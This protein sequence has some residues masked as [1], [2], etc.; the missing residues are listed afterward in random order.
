MLQVSDIQAL[1]QPD[2]TC[3]AGSGNILIVDADITGNLADYNVEIRQ[4]SETGT[5]VYSMNPASS[6]IQLTTLVGDDYFV[7]ATNNTT[8]CAI[9]TGIINVP[10]STRNPQI[11][12]VSITP[13]RDCTTPP[14]NGTANAGGIE[15]L[16]NN[17]YTEADPH[18][19]IQWYLGSDTI[20]GN[21]I[22]GE[23]AAILANLDATDYSVRVINMNT[24][25]RQMANYTVPNEPILPSIFSSTTVNNTVCDDDNDGNPANNGSFEVVEAI[26]DGAVL[27]Q[28][29]MT[30]SYSLEI[31]TNAGLTAVV[32]NNDPVSPFLYEELGVGTYYAT[33]TRTDSECASNPLTFDIEDSS[34]RPVIT[35][36]MQQADS[37]C[38]AGATPNGMLF[39]TAD[40]GIQDSNADYDFQWYLGTVVEYNAATATLL[41][42]G[43]DPGNGSTPSGVNASTLSGIAADTYTVE[44]TRLSSGCI[45]VEEFIVPNVPVDLEILQATITDATTCD[46]ANG[47]IQI[48]SV[49]RDNVTD[50]DFEYFDVDP[51]V[52][53]APTPLFTGVAGAPYT[54]ASAGIYYVVGTNTILNC[55]TLPFEVTVG[56]DLIKPQITLASFGFQAN[57][58]PSNPNG[59]F[60]ITSDGV[61]P[62][63]PNYSI[64][65]YFGSTTANTL[66]DGDIGGNGTLV[67]ADSA[68][69]LGLPN[70]FYTVEVR[71]STTGCISTETF[72]MADDIPNPTDISTST[73]ANTNCV[74][75]NGQLAA[76]VITLAPGRS[77]T[78]YNFY[79]YTGDVT[80][81]NPLSPDPLNPSPSPDFT[82]SLVTGVDAG[83]YTVFV[84]DGLDT[85][86]QSNGTL[87]EVEDGTSLPEYTLEI[88]SHVTVCFDEKDGF[89]KV[90]VPDAGRVTYEWLDDSG[91]LISTRSFASMLD[92]GAYTLRVTDVSTG[93]VAQEIFN[94]DNVSVT[95]P[96]PTVI[97]NNN[98]T[99]CADPNGGAVANVDGQQNGFLFEWFAEDDLTTPYTTG[100][101]V[102]T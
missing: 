94:I 72:E 41:A 11:D 58:D 20:P 2:T 78:D 26:F 81:S 85:F 47:V 82:G 27:N 28:V 99:N 96:D 57:C 64:Q 3:T 51:T 33:I 77:Q 80:A 54:L 34:S 62:I 15:I 95:P 89:V 69:V 90:E 35:I 36:A 87:V 43:T 23:T 73:S 50:Y 92:A 12:L 21:E 17:L 59:S 60:T 42:N 1:V 31:Y 30:G 100:A 4:G 29:A 68:T 13:D 55:V 40:G 86:C 45:S 52:T 63:S 65:W 75:P 46:P 79:W 16:I 70:G 61:D 37:T 10:D 56:E 76:S 93:C 84:V 49:T 7:I 88:V 14:A 32:T 44:V 91:V 101:E 102:F 5:A 39:A 22:A 24:D 19:D 9:A 97:A 53:P 83:V 48:S 74:N 67:G 71:N 8:G 6:P 38:A 98:R 18:I 25:C 66:D